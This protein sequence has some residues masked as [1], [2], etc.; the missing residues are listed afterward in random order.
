MK[1]LSSDQLD[2]LKSISKSA[3]K[4]NKVRPAVIIRGEKCYV[5]GVEMPNERYPAGTL[6][7]RVDDGRGATVIL[8]MDAKVDK[9]PD[10]LQIGSQF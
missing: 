6:N 5:W 7:I 2:T 9:I 8:S 4:D 10:Y 1:Q 3:E